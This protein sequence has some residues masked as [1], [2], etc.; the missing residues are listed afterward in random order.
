VP[1][2]AHLHRLVALATNCSQKQ[3]SDDD[4]ST[5]RNL[6]MMK[7]LLLTLILGMIMSGPAAPILKSF[8]GFGSTAA[9]AQD[10]ND[11]G[12]DNNDQGDD[13]TQ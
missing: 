10:D 9:Y 1:A 8:L 11:Q 2:L 6:T 12:E 4:A 7:K 5:V 3:A 13:D